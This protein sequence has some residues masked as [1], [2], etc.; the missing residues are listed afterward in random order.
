MSHGDVSGEGVQQGLLKL[1]EGTRAQVTNRGRNGAATEST[2]VDTTNILFIVG[3]S[4]TGI[5]QIISARPASAP[6]RSPLRRRVARA[7]V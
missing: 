5:E 1:I 6:S 7:S 4:F 2:T 3:G